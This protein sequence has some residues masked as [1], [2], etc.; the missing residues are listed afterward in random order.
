LPYGEGITFWALGEIV[1][2]HAGIYE[3]DSAEVAEEKLEAVL[4]ECTRLLGADGCAIRMLEDDEP[5][6]SAAAGAGAD[7]AVGSRSPASAWL[8]GD[9]LQSRSPVALEDAASDARL[10]ALDPML[11]GNAAYLGVPLVGPEG[12]PLGVLAVYARQSTTRVTMDQSKSRF[13]ISRSGTHLASRFSS[14]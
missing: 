4:P 7:D 8:S 14:S 5:V 9:V 12:A 10:R 2:A 6:V 11:A 3:S 1:K 13:S